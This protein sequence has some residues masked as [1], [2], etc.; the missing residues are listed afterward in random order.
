MK[1]DAE[2][3]EWLKQS[4]DRQRIFW[5][6]L[7]WLCREARRKCSPVPSE[8]IAAFTQETI[9]P[10]IDSFNYSLGRAGAKQRM[11][12]PARLKGDMPGLDGLWGFVGELRKRIEKEKA[13]P[14]ELLEKVVAF[15]EQFKADYAPL[16]DF[17]SSFDN[18]AARAAEELQLR[19]YESR[20]MIK[21][22]QTAL[23]QRRILKLSWTDGWPAI[24]YPDRPHAEDWGIY[25]YFN[26]AGVKSE[27]LTT[28]IGVPG[29]TFGKPLAPAMTGQPNMTSPSRTARALR[30]AE[31]SIAGA[32][33]EKCV[34][35]FG[36]L[37][38][39]PLPANSHLKQWSLIYSGGALW[40]CLTV[41]L[42]RALAVPG[43]LAAGLD[44][45]WRRTESGIRF[46][47][48]YEPE[49]KTIRELSIELQLPPANHEE[50]KPFEINLGPSRWD[51]RNITRLLPNWQLEDA[52][53]NTIEIRTAL[54]VRRDGYKD[55][56]K[57]Q[58]RDCLG[59]R[60]PAWID[61][62]GSRGFL[63]LKEEFKDDPVVHSIV[64]DFQAKDNG[65]NKISAMYFVR[66]TQRLE[67]GQ[68]Q[69][70][71][72]VCSYLQSKG[73]TRLIVEKSFIARVSRDHDNDK[74]ESLKKSRKY[75]QFAAVSRFV[76][77]LR[78]TASKY[79][80]AIDALDAINTSRICHYC[81]HLNPS[82]KKEIFVCENCAQVV[83][84]DDNASINLSRFGTDPEL[85]ELA[86]HAGKA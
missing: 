85:A 78:N 37:Q 83:K 65:I 42:Q 27:L 84:Q 11:K 45:G 58:L 80:I 71:H 40:L 32:N 48:L 66:Y 77:L 6:R 74:P 14:K 19:R 18:I 52:I 64:D 17:I 36:V 26:K 79:G 46:G 13:V 24:K 56:A 60:I 1:T 16:N 28:G 53:P 15:A 55:A 8:E 50:R 61:K 75:R 20:P 23:A 12:H 62:A 63:K 86:Q 51:R 35:H 70:S 30:E 39:R 81:N 68:L 21:A 10:A 72:D 2:I 49:S 5:N 67:C 33:K 25:F 34:F 38:H 22:F 44:I 4:I 31:I 82:T 69:V 76:S 9:L 47:T 7:A 43:P 57:A 3:P 54:S 29:L 59:D 73:I 41:E